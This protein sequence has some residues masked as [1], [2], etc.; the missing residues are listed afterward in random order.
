MIDL[1]SIAKKQVSNYSNLSP[2]SQIPTSKSIESTTITDNTSTS[3]NDSS[4][5]LTQ[6]VLNTLQDLGINPT[7]NFS[8]NTNKK[9]QTFIQNLHTALTQRGNNQEISPVETLSN[10]NTSQI[11]S[12][13]NVEIPQKISGGKNLKY[14]VDFS[15]ADLGDN[16]S[17][18]QAN[19]KTALENIG[20]YIRSDVVF[21]LKVLTEY[22]DT[23]MLARANASVVET[24]DNPDNVNAD[25]TF[26]ADSVRGVD[27]NSTENDSTLYINLA[28]LDQMSFSG[29]PTPDK[30]DF[31]TILTHEMLHGLAF[32]GMIDVANTEFKTA[33]DG[34]MSTKDDGTPIFIGRHAK[35]A[36]AGEPVP[37][38]PIDAGAGSA[39]Y[40]V[41]IQND[42]MSPSIK[43][44]EVKAISNLDVA[45]L[46]DMGI[47][48]T[49]TLPLNAKLQN[50]Y[51]AD[52]L[53]L[54]SSQKNNT[55]QADFT[56]VVQS[57]DNSPNV[58]LDDFLRQLAINTKISSTVQS[59][60]GFLF[61]AKA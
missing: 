15:G 5:S 44:G 33:Y 17:N 29:L 26:V 53:L 42:L 43:K 28:K 14:T 16:L 54:P 58:N 18:V 48:V 61:S 3:N 56:N 6:N 22:Q 37:L 59:G 23:S 1:S 51:N 10:V 20:Q 60:N 52:N 13:D 2:F 49:G 7:D 38:S 45:M 40:H 9:L 50:T 35:T 11:S 46:E 4:E 36:N 55:L 32:T 27:F 30:Y 41:A 19:V 24:K 21:N 47:N 25:T 31:T 12:S 39:Y 57:L 34:L 8:P